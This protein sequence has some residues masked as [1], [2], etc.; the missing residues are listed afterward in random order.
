MRRRKNLL[1]PHCCWAQHYL[2]IVDC[3]NLAPLVTY[4]IRPG[5]ILSNCLGVGRRSAENGV[6][7]H[8]ATANHVCPVDCEFY[9]VLPASTPKRILF[10]L[11]FE[12]VCT[13]CY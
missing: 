10:M 6:L 4:R 5:D 3:A 9:F 12:S 8:S 1:W 11:L 2:S 13:R 7:H